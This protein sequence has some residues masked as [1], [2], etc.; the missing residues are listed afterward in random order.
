MKITLKIKNN[1]RLAQWVIGILSLTWLIVRT[2]FKPSRFRYP[3]Q[4][5]CSFHVA[6]LFPPSAWMLFN[7][8]TKSIKKESVKYSLRFILLLFL[9]NVI[10][11]MFSSVF[12]N[13]TNQFLPNVSH[14]PGPI[15]VLLTQSTVDGAPVYQTSPYA[16]K[17]FPS[18]N[19]V[20]SIRDSNATN[21]DYQTGRHWEYIDQNVV[22]QMVISGIKTL[23]GAQSATEAW[24]LIIPYQPGEQIAIKVNF[25][26][27]YVGDDNDIDA[28]SET[29]NAVIDGLLLI[30]VPEEEIWVTDPSRTIPTRF[31]E[32]INHP[33]IKYCSYTH[34]GTN[35]NYFNIDYV[36][37]NSIHTN[38]ATC[39]AGEKIR[40]SQIFVDAEHLINIPIFKSHGRFITLALKNHYG[41]VI[42]KNNDRNSMHAYF[43]A[44][45]NVKG[46]DL[47][48]YN[49]L[50]DINNNPHIRD[51]TRLII[52]DGLFGNPRESWA[53]VKRWRIFNNDDPNILFFSADPV[54]ISS[55]MTDYIIEERGNQGHEHLHAAAKLGLGVHDHWDNF[56]NKYYIGFEYIHIDLNEKPITDQ[57]GPV[58]S[59]PQSLICQ[60]NDSLMIDVFSYVCDS[61]DAD[62]TLQI[63]YS[64]D[65]ILMIDYNNITGQILM[66]PAIDTN[67]VSEVIFTAIDLAGHMAKDTINIVIV[68][69]PVVQPDQIPPVWTLPDTLN[70]QAEDSLQINLYSYVHDS[71]D[72]DSTLILLCSTTPLLHTNLNQETGQLIL[73]SVVDSTYDCQIVLS[74]TDPA[75]N[76]T[77]DSLTII[78]LSNT[79][80]LLNEAPL[81][82]QFEFRKIYPNP[83]NSTVTIDYSLPDRDFVSIMIYNIN[84]QKLQTLLNKNQS[85]GH[86]QIIWNAAYFESGI[87]LI[88]IQTHHYSAVNKCI[89]IK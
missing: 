2:G 82:K 16:I 62:S 31:I 83:F 36:S 35:P 58:W 61:T 50:A 19:R 30:D 1:F 84:G 76:T 41:S 59:L 81:P 7:R 34:K 80:T 53:S 12:I 69:S 68:Q 15:G 37:N 46:C 73:K 43:N 10:V 77:R 86:Y 87:Y 4:R 3:C 18:P 74:A 33:N 72:N 22:N 13:N 23:T 54:A 5:L 56:Q 79:T 6:L 88:H 48:N 24:K 49:I 40:P 44:G 51:K 38:E 65:P 39:P 25:N 8:L 32:R 47:E 66:K 85:A 27:S 78:V 21:W 57:A 20:V 26:N 64:T 9:L 52:G 71:T 70:F 60:G 29:V 55:V 28:Y 75:N 67:Y 89:L 11:M 45:N 63:T 17:S 14:K 42:F